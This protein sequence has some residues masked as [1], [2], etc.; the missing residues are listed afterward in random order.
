VTVAASV[1]SITPRL[2]LLSGPSNTTLSNTMLETPAAL[3]QL[4]TADFHHR[5]PL[6]MH[7]P[8]PALQ[9]IGESSLSGCCVVL[10]LLKS[11]WKNILLK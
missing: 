6:S 9:R 2:R 10:D 3:L 4:D 11:K 5:R 8:A 7:S 1:A